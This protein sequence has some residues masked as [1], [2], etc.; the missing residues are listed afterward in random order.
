M[1][2]YGYKRHL[3][4]LSF[5]FQSHVVGCEVVLLMFL[6]EINKWPGCYCIIAHE[7]LEVPNVSLG[8]CSAV[9]V[10]AKSII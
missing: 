10:L 3:L 8:S 5:P 4:T 6:Q 2:E 7:V 9:S 1:T